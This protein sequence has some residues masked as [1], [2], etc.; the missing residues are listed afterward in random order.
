M[1]GASPHYCP[2]PTEY[3]FPTE[4]DRTYEEGESCLRRPAQVV[5]VVIDYCL[6][7]P[8]LGLTATHQRWTGTA[9]VWRLLAPANN[10][11]F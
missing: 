1:D 11:V 3:D 9:P 6:F 4:P 5:P 8:V 2:T 10:E 7:V